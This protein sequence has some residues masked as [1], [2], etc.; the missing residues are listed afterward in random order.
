LSQG[1]IR[2]S[3]GV[4]ITGNTI[5]ASHFNNEFN[6]LE[7][8][9]DALIG[10]AHDGSTGAGGPL[11]PTSLS[12]LSGNGM[13]ARISGT[14]FAARTIT[15]TSNKI[16]VTNGDGV[17]GNPTITIS[18]TYVGQTSITTVGTIATGTWSG[19]FGA[20]SGANLTNLTAANISAGTANIN[21]SGNA[22]TSSSTTGNAATATKL[23]TA[24]NINGTAFDGTADITVTA[25]AG[26]LTGAT[27]NATV[28]NTSITSVGTIAT[29]VWQGTVIGASFGGAG[30]INGILKANGSGTVSAA[31]AGTDYANSGQKLS[32]FAATTSAELAGVISDET[33]TGALVFAG[34]PTF[35]GTPVAPTAA[36][37]TN[38]T[39][40]ATT[41]FVAAAVGGGTSFTNVVVQTFTASGTY[42]PT[43]GM[44]FCIIELV[45]AG[46][47]GGGTNG[48]TGSAASGG[49][50]G[51]YSL[52]RLTAAQIGA[53]QTV[54]IGA[55]GTAGAAGA[56]AGGTGGTTS[57]GALIQATGGTGAASA[58][59]L[60]TPTLAGAGGV[61]S[62]GDV[63][64]QGGAGTCGLGNA[65]I[66][67]TFSGTGGNSFFGGGARGLVAAQGA[68]NAGGTN[69]GGG[70]SGGIR[71]GSDQNGGA[72]G[73]GIV[74][75]TEFI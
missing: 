8:F 64:L 73:A 41:A 59:G 58:G 37:G 67:A 60:T 68:G 31:A 14:T 75:I 53:S 70:G 34:S 42:T 69:S 29:G 13:V 51:G 1:Y 74:V 40:L 39:Q 17:A 52:R 49:G 20:V 55:A 57:V 65:T 38:T 11:P 7:S 30:T 22:A 48:G 61:G 26:T 19:L 71:N 27:L 15:G 25:A 9:A 18:A 43:S 35:T 66:A 47:G 54:T 3:A 62:L 44:K 6:A 46:G 45:G 36:P 4:I 50:G 63:N 5:Q 28:V 24:R 12:G 72:G 10:H 32:Y 33:G 56:G 23:A 16:D 2:Q 21:I